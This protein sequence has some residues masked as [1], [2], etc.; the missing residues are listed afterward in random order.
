MGGPDLCDLSL[1]S[2]VGLVV[3]FCRIVCVQAHRILSLVS[4]LPQCG[5]RGSLPML[6]FYIRA[7]PLNFLHAFSN[8]TCCAKLKFPLVFVCFNQPTR[9]ARSVYFVLSLTRFRGM[10]CVPAQT[11]HDNC[12][13]AVFAQVWVWRFLPS[14]CAAISSLIAVLGW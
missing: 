6:S 8:V 4:L 14:V 7:T 5:I 1:K 3:A 2:R 11:L 10:C 13:V 12:S 9:F